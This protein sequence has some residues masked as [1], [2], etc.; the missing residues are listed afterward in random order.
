MFAEVGLQIFARWNR[1]ALLR[2]ARFALFFIHVSSSS[3]FLAGVFLGAIAGLGLSL[4]SALGVFASALGLAS[5]FAVPLA[6][7]F[8][9]PFAFAA[10]AD[11]FFDFLPPPCSARARRS[12]TASASVVVCGSAP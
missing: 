11:L 12:S 2:L 6:L 10:F 7:A 5:A 3:L 9:A 4:V 1:S 8:C